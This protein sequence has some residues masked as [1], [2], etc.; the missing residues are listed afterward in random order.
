MA[1]KRGGKSVSGAGKVVYNDIWNRPDK[2][3]IIFYGSTTVEQA[4][5]LGLKRIIQA[6]RAWDFKWEY[7]LGKN[8]IITQRNIIL[9]GGLKDL[10]SVYS[11]QGE[12]FKTVILDEPQFIKENVLKT[13]I[14]EVVSGSMV[15]FEGDANVS[16]IGNPFPIHS[17][18]LWDMIQNPETTTFRINMEDNPEISEKAREKF[19][20]D[21]LKARGETMETLS[22]ST[23]RLLFG[24]W[25]EDTSSLVLS[26]D[27]TDEFESLPQDRNL[28]TVSGCDLGFDDK[29]AICV[30]RYDPKDDVVYVDYEF[31]QP[32]MT[33]KEVAE[34]YDK[35][36]KTYNT[37]GQNAIDTQGGGKQTAISL[38]VNHGIPIVAAKKADKMH[39]VNLLR[40][41]NRM[42]KLKVRKDSALAADARHILFAKHNKKLD[43]DYFHSDI[44]H[45]V[46]YAFRFIYME[47]KEPLEEKK[48]IFDPVEDKL[49]RIREKTEQDLQ[50]VSPGLYGINE[51]DDFDF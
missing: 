37:N 29:T 13:F 39:Y 41:Y 40:S 12:P 17:G 24:I 15:D 42:G 18:Y 16:F 20:K 14:Q 51:N 43:D 4:R 44:F 6:Q 5:R 23:K 50:S 46:L 22:N 49:E 19:I 45:A 47:F 3:G 32:E 36:L 27:R 1:Q 31:Q 7:K 2:G 33:I 48:K 35:V 28:I 21:E 26:F 8:M 30:L 25:E 11:Y 10:K 38:N 9:F 34:Q